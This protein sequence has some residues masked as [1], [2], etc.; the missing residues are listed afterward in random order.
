MRELQEKP[1]DENGDGA[2][3]TLAM[4]GFEKQLRQLEAD[5][6]SCRVM[7]WQVKYI[8]RGE[9][10][11]NV[12]ASDDSRALVGLPET[13]VR[14]INQ[15]IEDVRSGKGFVAVVGMFS[16]NFRFDNKN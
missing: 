16:N 6:V 15:R 1:E 13:F 12:F 2:Q 7:F 10:I 9:D 8:H 14:K 4:N 3:Q 5:Q 11:D